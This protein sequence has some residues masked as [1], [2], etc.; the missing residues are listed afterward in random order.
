M[1][2]KT[3][4]TENAFADEQLAIEIRRTKAEVPPEQK[5]YG[6]ALSGGGI[7]SATFCLGMVRALAKKGELKKYDYLSTVSGG[8][9]FGGMLGRLYDDQHNALAVEKGLA[10]DRSILLSWLRK[11]AAI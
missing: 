9:Y 3:A 1:S 4:K 2:A 5:T 8:G 11:M 6:L 7:R 10:S